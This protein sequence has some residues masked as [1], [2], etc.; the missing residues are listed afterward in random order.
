MHLSIFVTDDDAGFV[1]G[2]D[3]CSVCVSGARTSALIN[4]NVEV[5]L[6]L[7][8]RHL[9]YYSWRIPPQM[10]LPL[11]SDQVERSNARTIAYCQQEFVSWKGVVRDEWFLPDVEERQ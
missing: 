4:R 9:A 11:Y 10:Y 8:P 5:A 1:T 6:P 3:P 2:D 7:S